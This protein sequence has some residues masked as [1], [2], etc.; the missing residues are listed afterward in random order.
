MP[1][2]ERTVEDRWARE[3]EQ[4]AADYVGERQAR[5][6]AK[7]GYFK[8]EVA[9]LRRAGIKPP[10]PPRREQQSTTA[11]R[12]S[13]A[14]VYSEGVADGAAGRPHAPTDHPDY[15]AGYREGKA[16]RKT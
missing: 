15:V 10:Q 13:A 11:P 8:A 7:R 1:S 9:R 4:T 3:L 6:M 14:A 5:S 12:G 2:K 16:L